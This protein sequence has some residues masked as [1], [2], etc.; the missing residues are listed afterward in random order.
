MRV[1]LRVAKIPW[2]GEIA[3]HYWFVIHTSSGADRWEVWQTP[4]L[5]LPC[6]GHLY[7][8]LLP[9]DAGVG[10]GESW[11]EH[12]WIEEKAIVLAEVIESSPD[13]YPYCQRYG[14]WPG[15]NSNT[16]VQWVIDQAQIHYPLSR[17]G[18]GKQYHRG[19]WVQASHSTLF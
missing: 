1:E 2:I 7:Q 4:H 14:Y 16:Y 15:P 17:R 6:W 13:R 19:A 9:I 12:L 18:L 10:N 11:A 5:K 8:N 3:V